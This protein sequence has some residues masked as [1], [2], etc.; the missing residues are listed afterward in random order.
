MSKFV[1]ISHLQRFAGMSLNCPEDMITQ[2]SDQWLSFLN[3]LSSPTHLGSVEVG[4][5]VTLSAPAGAL[6]K[7][8]V[9]ERTGFMAA[10]LVSGHNTGIKHEMLLKDLKPMWGDTSLLGAKVRSE[11]K[12]ADPRL[13]HVWNSFNPKHEMISPSRLLTRLGQSDLEAESTQEPEFSM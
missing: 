2:M 1:G 9:H 5:E 13:Y 8:I 3:H 4:S 6:M 11:R 10:M 7:E 12:E